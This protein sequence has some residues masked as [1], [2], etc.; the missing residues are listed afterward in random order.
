MRNQF[1][2]LWWGYRLANLAAQPFPPV[3]TLVPMMLAA[4][5][6]LSA[7]GGG[8]DGGLAAGPVVYVEGTDRLAN[9]QQGSSESATDGDIYYRGAAGGMLAS[10]VCQHPAPF[11]ILRIMRLPS[12]LP[13]AV[14]HHLP[15]A[16]SAPPMH[17]VGLAM[18]ALSQSLTQVWMLTTPTLPLTSQQAE[19]SP[20]L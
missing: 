2:G 10:W 7:C 3:V 13:V 17:V 12:I 9:P 6:V 20:E 14:R 16:N 18:E 4:M 19:I 11:R 15:L 5:L 1:F 8:G